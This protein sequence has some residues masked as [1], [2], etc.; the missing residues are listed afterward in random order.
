MWA[1]RVAKEGPGSQWPWHLAQL[2]VTGTPKITGLN[3]AGDH[4]E[5]LEAGNPGLRCRPHSY[6]G[7]RLVH[8]SYSSR[9]WL[10]PHG[11]GWCCSSSH[12][13]SAE[14]PHQHCDLPFLGQNLVT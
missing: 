5:D 12:H 11:S 3:K 2:P 14:K 10:A 8:A 9:V 6:E 1:V 7:P 13:I 4:V